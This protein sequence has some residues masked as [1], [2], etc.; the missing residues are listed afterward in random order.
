MKTVLVTGSAGFLGRHIAARFARA[1]WN[2]TGID[3]TPEMTGAEDLAIRYTAMRLPSDQFPMLLHDRRPDVLVHCAGHASVPAS[4]KDPSGDFAANTVLTFEV[5][6][7]LRRYQPRCRFILLSSAAVYGNPESLPVSE[8]HP[9]RPLSPYGFHKRQCEL[10]C[11]EFSS[12]FGMQCVVARIFSAYG[13]GLQ[14][15]VVWDILDQ[16]ARRDLIE[17]HGTGRESRDFIHAEDVAQA[18]EVL[19]ERGSHQD[20]IYNVATGRETSIADLASLVARALDK[21]CEI[22]F[23]GHVRAGDPLN[24]RA[25][26]AKLR[27]IGFVP[28]LTLEGGLRQLVDWASSQVNRK[29]LA[30]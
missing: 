8:S 16:V 3:G 14:R 20:G 13:P 10:A 7:A 4:M 11:E 30:P 12:V 17:L 1:G 23:D 15:Q 22:R 24:W 27:E 28:L 2:V 26:I 25:D 29:A 19:A 5:L 18:V 6:E 9:V 21:K